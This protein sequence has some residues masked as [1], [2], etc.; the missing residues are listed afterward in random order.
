MSYSL[1]AIS[2]FFEICGT[3]CMKIS[4]GY[5]NIPASLMIFVFY[6]ISFSIFPFALKNI[7]V[8]LAYAIWSGVG[9][10]SM[11]LIG[12]YYFKEPAT[13]IKMVSIF[14]VMVGVLGLNL[15]DKLA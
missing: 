8:S 14:I 4:D 7:D 3:V 15:S 5:S 11:T 9:T 6:G 10:A 12:I 13:A 2:I 1:L